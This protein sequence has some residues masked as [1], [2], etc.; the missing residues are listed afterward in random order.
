[1]VKQLYICRQEA[2]KYFIYSFLLSIF[3]TSCFQ[4]KINTFAISEDS[5]ILSSTPIHVISKNK[6]AQFNFTLK[7]YINAQ[8]SEKYY[9]E[10]R[11]KTDSQTGIF[12]RKKSTLKF[13][14][15]GLNIVSLMPISKPKVKE[16]QFEPFLMIEE[17][18]YEISRQDLESIAYA[19][20]VE[21]E[22]IGKNK[23]ATAKFGRFMTFVPF[24]NFLMES[25]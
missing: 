3:L 14:I 4:P 9:I 10:V 5:G 15:D 11:W 6:D 7:K 25:S 2:I 1:M 24:K 21:V 20:N 12:D 19:K 23:V 18:T 16:Y 8:G 13:L 17:C 22:L